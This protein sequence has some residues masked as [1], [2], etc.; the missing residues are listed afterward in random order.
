MAIPESY[1]RS[2][3]RGVELDRRPVGDSSKQD[4]GSTRRQDG[5]KLSPKSTPELDQLLE[6]CSA[7]GFVQK[8]KKV[9][10]HHP[11]E[12]PLY[13]PEGVSP[14]SPSSSRYTYSKLNFDF[15]RK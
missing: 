10:L 13:G 1:L 3:E 2:L 15:I 14:T 4:N 9:S 6:D 12:L 7:E 11:N 8:L 5:D